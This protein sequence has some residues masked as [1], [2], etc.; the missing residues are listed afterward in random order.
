[1]SADV[2]NPSSP[3]TSGAKYTLSPSKPVFGGFIKLKLINY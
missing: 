1:M 2:S 3:R